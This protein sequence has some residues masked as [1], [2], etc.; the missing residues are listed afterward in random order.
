MTI[1]VVMRESMSGWIRIE[2]EEEEHPFTF[3]IRAYTDKIFSIGAARRFKGVAEFGD[4]HRPVPVSGEVQILW[5]GP[6]YSLD[7]VHDELGPLHIEGK[8]QYGKNGWIRSLVTCPLEVY[9]EGKQIGEAE[10]AYRDPIWRFFF[11]A[12]RLVRQENAF[13]SDERTSGA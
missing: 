10:V 4:F 8:K 6:R 7:L 1:G 9:R 11:R 3:S 2:G 5:S 12:F 13:G